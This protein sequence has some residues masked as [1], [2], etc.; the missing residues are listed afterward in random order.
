MKIAYRIITPIFAVGAVVMGLFLKLFYFFYSK[1]LLFSKK[2]AGG[3][4]F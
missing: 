4:L 1:L 2:S 3:L